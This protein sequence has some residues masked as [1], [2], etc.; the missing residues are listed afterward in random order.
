MIKTVDKFLKQGL[1]VI[2]RGAPRESG[3][4]CEAMKASVLN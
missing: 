1:F 4:A 2:D 3:Q